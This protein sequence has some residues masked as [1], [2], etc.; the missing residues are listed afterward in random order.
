MVH[1]GQQGGQDETDGDDFEHAE[2]V[3]NYF[4]AAE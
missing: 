4:D 3:A 2:R 1:I